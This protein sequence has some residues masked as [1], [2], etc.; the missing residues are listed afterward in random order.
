MATPLPASRAEPDT[1]TGT[2][3]PF[4]DQIDVGLTAT[5]T[6]GAM[7]SL[8]VTVKDFEAALPAPSVA[9]QVTDVVPRG[10]VVPDTGAHTGT[11]L[12]ETKSVAVAT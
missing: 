5:V 4:G 8:T 6:V 2:I 3:A 10:N 7:V 1:V 9:V 12:T 11:I